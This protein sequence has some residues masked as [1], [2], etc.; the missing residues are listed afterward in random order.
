MRKHFYILFLLTLTL[1]GFTNGVN[2]V[3]DI[4]DTKSI[5]KSMFI[6]NFATLVDWP[7]DC[8][9]GDFII[10]VYGNDQAVYDELNSKYSGKAI[11]S[12]EIKVVKYATKEKING[13][14]H[15]LYITADKSE[16]ISAFNT[17]F[18]GKSTLLITDKPGYLEKGAIINFVIDANRN[19]KQ[20]YEIDKSNA[21][22]HKLYV[23]SK[24]TTLAAKVVE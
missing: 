13:S 24:L 18:Y 1:S 15:I 11:G 5:Y 16:S 8:R 23:P 2:T 20:S 7:A 4:V 10:G 21:K 3:S 22:S 6:Y 12:Q 17:K 14:I 9:K 19:N